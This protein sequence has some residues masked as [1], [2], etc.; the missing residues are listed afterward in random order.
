LVWNVREERGLRVSENRALRE[1]FGP[2][3]EE[4]K[5]DWR[6]LR[7]TNVHDLYC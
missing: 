7:D 4:V 5:W 6:K 1:T 3:S 2:K